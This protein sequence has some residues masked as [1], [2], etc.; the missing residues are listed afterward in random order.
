MFSSM[1]EMSML[2]GVSDIGVNVD[3]FNI[4]LIP[5][6]GHA[7]ADYL[8]LDMVTHPMVD[9]QTQIRIIVGLLQSL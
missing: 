8:H 1:S 2:D 5:N 4:Q 6:P 7:R 9:P 3:Q